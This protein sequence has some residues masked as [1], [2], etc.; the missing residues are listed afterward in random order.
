VSG[1]TRSHTLTRRTL[2]KGLNGPDRTARWLGNGLVAL[3]GIDEHAEVSGTTIASDPT[4]AGLTIVDVRTWTARLVDRDAT[5]VVVAGGR[6]FAR[7]YAESPP[8]SIRAYDFAGR[9]RFELD[10][11]SNEWLQAAR[12]RAYVGNRVVDA[13]SGRIV[14]RLPGARHVVLLPT[15]G[16]QFPL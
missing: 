9:Q 16:S 8:T 3:T 4:P 7:G 15:D 5:T 6:L 13:Q 11:G 10:V 14:R 1:K 2:A 12:N